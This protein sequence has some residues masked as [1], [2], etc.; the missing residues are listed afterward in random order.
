MTYSTAVNRDSM[1]AY[2]GPTDQSLSELQVIVT[3]K[4]Q[5]GAM[6]GTPLGNPECVIS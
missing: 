5:R 3:P 2:N 4:T 1:D 6:S